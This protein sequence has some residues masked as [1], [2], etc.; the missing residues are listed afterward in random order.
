ME[1]KEIKISLW[2]FYV[3]VAGIVLLIGATAIGWITIGKYK[4]QEGNTS[5]SSIE[6]G[7]YNINKYPI[8]YNPEENE[9]FGM[10]EE[11]TFYSDNKFEAYIGWGMKI[12]GD[13][14]ISKDGDINCNIKQEAS[15]L[16]SEKTD[17]FG[18]AQISFKI[19]ENNTIE[20]VESSNVF[21]IYVLGLGDDGEYYVTNNTKEY[22][23]YPF[24]KSARFSLVKE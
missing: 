1:K 5:V 21:T 23:L 11:I 10:D 7:T 6:F 22:S 13:Y 20:V 18:S 4:Q 15:H 17:I 3:I 14:N 24:Q 19:L 16:H 2:L 12:F 9:R 8:E